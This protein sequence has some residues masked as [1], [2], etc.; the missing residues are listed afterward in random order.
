MGAPSHR[1]WA[2]EEF[3]QAELGDR[4][5][6]QRLVA[7][8]AA[9]L[10]CPSGLVSEVF[11]NAADRQ[12]AYDLLENE[13]VAH[14]AMAEPMFSAS[15]RRAS[16]RYAFV[17]I[18]GSSLTLTDRALCKGFGPIGN[19]RSSGRGLKVI[20]AYGVD[21]QGVPLGVL[22]QQWWARPAKKRKKHRKQCR[23]EEKETKYW[24][25]SIKAAVRRLQMLTPRTRPVIVIDREADSLELLNAITQCNALFVIRSNH[26]RRLQSEPTQRLYLKDALAKARVVGMHKVQV[27]AAPGRSARTAL[28]AMRVARVALRL[29]NRL[30]ESCTSYEANV[31]EARE[32]GRLPKG[33]KP[34]EWRLLTN[35]PLNRL[36]EV[37]YAIQ[38]YAWRWR[39]EDFHRSWKS[40]VCNIESSQL[41]H[42]DHVVKW[43]TI[44]AAVAARAER[45]KQRSRV[46]PE[47]PA[48]RE[49]SSH[50]IAA[51]LFL[52]RRQ[53]KRTETVPDKMPTL[54]Q[55][56]RWIA[57]L[58]GYTGKSSGGPPGSTTIRRGLEDVLLAAE[59]FA[60][61]QEQGKLR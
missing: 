15:A 37:R 11:K 4:R 32:I 34:L 10:A 57:D 44:M 29:R 17:V 39:I 20:T 21:E 43:A 13:K 27:S 5:R 54:G 30:N 41:R 3:G 56:V 51:V 33:E 19:R 46:E 47:L 53:K 38:I 16:G 42:F 26:N 8:A 36:H 6:E 14:H 50:E 45:L 18:D 24:V 55:A 1:H 7:M 60:G 49:L 58:G 12:G 22:D 2:V 25:A 61:L 59:I 48:D 52:K 40:G 23:L 31:V 9:A 35:L 28:L